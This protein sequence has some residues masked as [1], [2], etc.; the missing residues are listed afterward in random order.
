[1]PNLFPEGYDELEVEEATEEVTGYRKSIYFDFE[2]G[3]FL[4]TGAN[5]LIESTGSDAWIHWCIKCLH[6]QR[7]A[8]RAY[9]TDYGID[10]ETIFSYTTREEAENELTREI[11]EALEAD[12][13]QRLDH[14]ESMTFEWIDDTSLE[15]ELTLVG[16]DGNTAHIRTT[17]SAA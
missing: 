5:R 9:S 13:Y 12:P 7:F 2:K 4:R 17:L 1:M 16:I 11:T 3:D 10:Y 14:I 8:Y 15:V 6:T